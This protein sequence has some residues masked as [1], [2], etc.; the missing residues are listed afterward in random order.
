M[1]INWKAGLVLFLL[2]VFWQS[3]VSVGV[4]S[5]ALFPSP[6]QVLNSQLQWFFSGQLL[7][8]VFASFWRMAFGLVLG[9]TLG[10]LI[11]LLMGQIFFSEETIAPIFHILRAFPPVA[12]IPLVIVWFGI[13]D[14]AK[15]F[16][17]AF[18]VFF[19]VWLSA[20]LGSKSIHRDY[21]RVAKLFSKSKTKTFFRV[22]IPATTPF[23][24]NGVRI[25]IATAFIMVFVSELAGA[26]TGLGYRI[27]LAQIT[28]QIDLM[29]AGLMVLGIFAAGT[30]HLFVFFSRK[31]FPW[32][33]LK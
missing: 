15:I 13:G 23:L 8:D 1:K 4:V 25:G 20:F 30:D 10:V 14:T 17:I 19:P 5:Q 16:S 2:T 27:A 21:L 9:S 6:V 12:I 29:V 18:A 3:I 26:S 24:V 32:V 31:L 22:I 33:E 7:T 11:G 28:Y